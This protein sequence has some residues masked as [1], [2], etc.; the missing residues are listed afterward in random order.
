M[1]KEMSMWRNLFRE[2][3]VKTLNQAV[4]VGKVRYVVNLSETLHDHRYSEIANEIAQRP[5]VKLVLIA[6][7][8]SSG[9]TT[10][11]KRL[12]LH[13]RVNGLN[14]III[15]L[16][17]YFRNRVDTPRDENGE[18]DF[19]CLEALDVPFLNEQLEQLF[20][21]KR[22]QI[23][24]YDF[25]S[26]TRKFEGQYLQLTENDV[27]IMEGIHGLN[28]GLTPQIPDE[29]KFKLYVSVLTPIRIDEKTRMQARDY[30][31]LRRMVRDNQFRGMSAEDT[32]LRWPSVGAGE[33]KYILPFKN[34]ADAEFNSALFYEIPMLKCY[35][36]PLLQI[37]PAKSP[38]YP[39]AC[40]LLDLVRSVIAMTPLDIRHIPPTSI[41]REFIGGS[42]F[43]Y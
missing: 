4:A 33:E 37:L 30:R 27:L 16:D 19:E 2:N 23:P 22:V 5:G 39:E 42:S 24:K 7:P 31:L 25:P 1:I 8:S 14:P 20:A 40:R 12:A 29:E 43:H 36:E 18:Y 3:N 10:S 13:M 35:A 41:I 34:L 38:A 32:I 17:D 6:G 21:G 9:K 28:P 15:S 26:G 11:S